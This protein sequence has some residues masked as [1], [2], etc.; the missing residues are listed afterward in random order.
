MLP[1]EDLDNLLADF[2]A[3][4]RSETEA[5]HKKAAAERLAEA[6]QWKQGVPT[7]IGSGRG[8][9]RWK[10][11]ALANALAVE[12]L[13]STAASTGD[14]GI[15]SGFWLFRSGRRWFQFHYGIASTVVA[16]A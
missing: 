4:V 2:H 5:L 14:Q 11:H 10:M 6:I 12:L 8:S 7:A 15:E 13:N 3:L 9:V 16:R 1:L